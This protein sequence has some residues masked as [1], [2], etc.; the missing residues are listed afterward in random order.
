[1]VRVATQRFALL[2]LGR[3]ARSHPSGKKLR[4]RKLLEMAAESQHPVHA[5]SGG[6]FLFKT[7]I[8]RFG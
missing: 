8:S 4:R 1:M 5:M 2:A 6:V 7:A 3:T